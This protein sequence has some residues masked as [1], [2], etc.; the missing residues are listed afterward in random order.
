MKWLI[1]VLVGSLL[2][3]LAGAQDSPKPAL[4][5]GVAVQ[6]A[7]AN[8][9][10]EVK[11]ADEPDTTVVAIAAD[12]RA[13]AGVEPVE[14]AALSSLAAPERLS[15]W[16]SRFWMRYGASRWCCFR[17]RPQAPGTRN[18]FRRTGSKWRCP[19][20]ARFHPAKD[21]S[22]TAAARKAADLGNTAFW[23]V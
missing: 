22:L 5:K 12:G 2:A 4:R 17:P 8:H 1:R 3:C 14:P 6:M 16:Y 13:Y 21:H 10:V 11:A 7:V 18:P 15:R 23:N 9:A 20:E 19:I